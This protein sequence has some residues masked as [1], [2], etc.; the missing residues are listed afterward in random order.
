MPHSPR[1]APKTCSINREDILL[2]PVSRSADIDREFPAIRSELDLRRNVD[3]ES[4]DAFEC[5][6]SVI[7]HKLR[8]DITAE[9]SNHLIL[10]RRNHCRGKNPPILSALLLSCWRGRKASDV[11]ANAVPTTTTSTI[12]YIM[13][14][15]LLC[16][17][18][19]VDKINVCVNLNANFTL[20][21]QHSDAGGAYGVKH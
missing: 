3:I 4:L 17:F 9:I 5:L 14:Y 8:C 1:R 11:A 13:V 19:A 20:L 15:V 2:S 6:P 12:I 16:L 21:S 7:D 18:I 10:C